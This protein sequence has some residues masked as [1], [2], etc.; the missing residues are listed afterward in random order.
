MPAEPEMNRK[1]AHFHLFT[2]VLLGLSLA[3]LG[4]PSGGGGGGGG[5]LQV[6]ITPSALV[7]TVSNLRANATL[8]GPGTATPTFT[9]SWALNGVDTGITTSVLDRVNTAKTQTWTVTVTATAD[10]KSFGP[11]SDD[12]TII[13]ALPRVSPATPVIQS[14]PARNTC[15]GTTY[16]VNV[17]VVDDDDDAPGVD[18]DGMNDCPC[19]IFYTWTVIPGNTVVA[20]GVGVSSI[21]GDLLSPG[22]RLRVLMTANDGE[23]DGLEFSSAILQGI[24][25]CPPATVREPRVATHQSLPAPASAA[26]ASE[27]EEPA[28][29]L[30][31]PR[32]PSDPLSISETHVCSLDAA[33]GVFCTGDESADLTAAP[34]GDYAVIALG[35]DYACA[36]RE[37]DRG[38]VC[39][40]AVAPETGLLSPPA[41]AFL[42]IGLGL[43]AACGLRSDGE[44]ACWGSRDP[45]WTELPAGPFVGLDVAESY[46]CAIT[47]GREVSC[48][49]D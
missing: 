1:R 25:A 24:Q 11:V 27:R 10:G 4:C 40:G 8:Q 16:S 22:A 47:A 36:I 41:G 38:V 48:W 19:T 2:A 30:S 14:S 44:L 12:L 29:V 15:P 49:G 9:Y 18:Q 33:G 34:E 32:A 39:W 37:Q 6:I 5:G 43:D 13:N 31:A 3:G 17:S 35:A 46:A 20:S 42:T 21:Q 26:A 23:Q 7:T 28:V 45:A